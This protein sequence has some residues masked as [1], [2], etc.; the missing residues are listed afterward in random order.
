MDLKPERYKIEIAPGG[1]ILPVMAGWKQ[2]PG[3]EGAIYYYWGF[4]KNPVNDWLVTEYKKKNNGAPP[5]FFVAGGMAAALA[6]VEAVKKAKSTDT[7]KLIAAMEGMSFETPKG[8]MTFRKE[9][10]QALQAMYHWRMKQSPPDNTDLLELVREIPA[11]EL[12]L[13]IKNKR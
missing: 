5:D 11:N 2:F 3:L 10:H 12:K 6:I 7:E 13:P 8:T 1:N 9:D 4:P